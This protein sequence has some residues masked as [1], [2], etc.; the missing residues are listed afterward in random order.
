MTTA[1]GSGTPKIATINSLAV[2]GCQ[3]YDAAFATGLT[4]VTT[5]TAAPDVTVA[6]DR[7]PPHGSHRP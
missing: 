3:L 1:A 5:G 6:L 4:V 2:T 7:S